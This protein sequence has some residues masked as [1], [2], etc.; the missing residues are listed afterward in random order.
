MAAKL[1]I[2]R[3]AAALSDAEDPLANFQPPDGASPSLIAM[4][5][6]YLV[7]QV[8][9]QRAKPKVSIARK[10]RRKLKSQRSPPQS[11]SSKPQSR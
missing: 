5:Q 7:S 11:I 1:E 10:H 4:Q 2:A 3:L 6:A 9:E 8:S